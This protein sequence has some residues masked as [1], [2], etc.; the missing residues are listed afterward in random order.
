MTTLTFN[1]TTNRSY[2]ANGSIYSPPGVDP[3]G[4]VYILSGYW[5]TTEGN[6]RALVMFDFDAIRL[7]LA[8]KTVTAC[9]LVYYNVGASTGIDAYGVIGT[10]NYTSVP[11]TWED[12]RVNQDRVRTS[13]GRDD[14]TVVTLSLG[15]TIGAEFKSGAATGL[16]VGPGPSTSIIYR[17]VFGGWNWPVSGTQGPPRLEFDVADAN[18]TPTAPTLNSPS[19]GAVMDV[20]GSGG[21]FNWTFNDPNNFD[22]QTAYRFRIRIADGSYRWW[23]GSTFQTTQ[24]DLVSGSRTLVLPAGQWNNQSAVNYW[25]VATRDSASAWSPY[26]AE[27]PLY[28]STPPTVTVQE[29][30]DPTT[31]ARPLIKWTFGSVGGL[32]QYGWIAQ[33]VESSVYSQPGYDPENFLGQIWGGSGVGDASSVLPD[34]NLANHKTYRAYVKV[35]S[36]P[37]PSGGVQYSA[38]TY[39]QF[40][41]HVPPFAPAI[42]FPQNG[43]TADL[44]AGFTLTWQNNFYGT[45]TTQAAFAI[46]RQVNAGAYQWWNGAAWQSTEFFLAGTSPSYAFRASEN[47]N[48]SQITYA[49]AMRDGYGGQSPYSTGNTVTGTTAAQV[50]VTAPASVVAESRPHVSWLMYDAENDPQQTYQVRIIHS[51]NFTAAGSNPLTATAV[52][53]STEVASATTRDVVVPVDLLAANTYRAYVR[54]KTLGVY[55]GWTYAEF[56]VLLLA[57][58]VPSATVVV[59]DDLASATI[60]VQGRDSIFDAVTSL[61]TGGWEA[62]TNTTLTGT[63]AFGSSASGQAMRFTSNAAGNMIIR[64]I[65]EYTVTPGIT[66]TGAA[67]LI[68]TLGSLALN[69]FVSIEWLD[70]SNVILSTSDGSVVNDA[71][72]QRSIITA[73]APNDAATARLKVTMSSA[74]GSAASHN[75]FDPILRPG[76]G[77][78]W[79]P[80]GLLGSTYISINETHNFRTIR[81]GLNIPVPTASQIITVIDEEIE[82]GSLQA[83]E[84]TNRAVYPDAVLTAASYLTEDVR[85]VS[86]FLWLSDPL[87]P[88]SAHVFG[89][90]SYEEITRPVRQGV[91]RPISR[92]D[93]VITTGVRGLREGGFTIITPTRAERLAFETFLNNTSVLLMRIPPDQGEDEGDT[94]YVKF[95]GDAPE[96]R[97]LPSRT[98]HRQFVQRWTE[99]LRPLDQLE[100]EEPA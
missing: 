82:M 83:Y 14:N 78:E 3:A 77:D 40:D 86:G 16:A 42:T 53:D 26:S 63:I 88:G 28:A 95:T 61:A 33:I 64:T 18:L 97:P 59:N 7:A 39:K 100:Y 56:Q 94:I 25:S 48:G 15:T 51:A 91:F 6:M 11:T 68:N 55:S 46:R 20:Q 71:S 69:G 65:T 8:T 13:T 21:T 49:V 37:N 60:T 4:Y 72:A 12:S 57:P 58:A 27:R 87:I 81:H 96:A 92:A 89:P 84:I 10:H 1:A 22:I 98:S 99:Q 50:T 19:S 76:I 38:Y 9:R 41:V 29:P 75:I 52:W 47:L 45:G 24:F 62:G 35:G 79:S 74:S 34:V 44:Q 80:G 73:V 31:V 30:L 93:A 66:Y 85:W 67:T 90:Q 2:R 36:S 70:A 5:N 23:N 54:V 17:S 43:G 32:T